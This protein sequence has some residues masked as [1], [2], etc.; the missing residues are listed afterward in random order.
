MTLDAQRLQQAV[1][2]AHAQYATLAG[3]KKFYA[4]MIP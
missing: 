2:A 3:G 4:L 1:D